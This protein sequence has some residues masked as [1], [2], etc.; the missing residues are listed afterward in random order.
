MALLEF[1]CLLLLVDVVEIILKCGR[2]QENY[3]DGLPI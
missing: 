2:G 1:S 3:W